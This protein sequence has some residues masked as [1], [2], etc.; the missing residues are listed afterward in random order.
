MFISLTETCSLHRQWGGPI[1]VGGRLRSAHISMETKH[2]IVLPQ[3]HHVVDLIIDHSYKQNLHSG[4]QLTQAIIAQSY[5]IISAR[6][7]IH[8]RIFKC[9]NCSQNKP[10]N[11]SPL[12]GDLPASRVQAEFKPF[13]SSG[14]DFC[15][16]FTVKIKFVP[17]Y[18]KS[19][20]SC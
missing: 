4:P 1:R 11:T 8:S 18:L 9:I 19:C 7:I 14:C 6:Q 12:M 16:P 3:H 15:G 5:W 2:P 17:P 13:S 10:C 20:S